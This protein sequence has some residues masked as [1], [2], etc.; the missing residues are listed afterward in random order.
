MAEGEGKRLF[1]VTGR[2]G[3]DTMG[4]VGRVVRREE[5]M[6][7][8]T[9]G[10]GLDASRYEEI[11]AN[12]LPLVIVTDPF[13]SLEE[14]PTSTISYVNSNLLSDL[15]YGADLVREARSGT[16]GDLLH[17]L[18]ADPA[19]VDAYFETLQKDYLVR[20]HEIPFRGANGKHLVVQVSS[21]ILGLV[22]GSYYLQGIFSDVTRRVA[23]EASLR[24]REEVMH[25]DLDLAGWVQRSLIPN[26]LCTREIT[27]EVRYI[28][29]AHVGGDY[30]DFQMVGED[31]VYVSVCDVSGHGVAAAL[32][33][34]RV[35]SEVARWIGEGLPPAEIVTSL[36]WFFRLHFGTRGVFLSIFIGRLDLRMGEFSFAGAGHPPALLVRAGGS[37]IEPLPSRYP[38]VGAVDRLTRVDEPDARRLERGDKIVLYTDGLFE[39]FGPSRVLLGTEG[40]GEILKRH[41][42][43]E[44]MDL[45]SAILEEVEAYRVGPRQDDV[46]VLILQAGA[47]PR[48]GPAAP[49]VSP[50]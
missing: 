36:N 10:P 15:G 17:R 13:P 35:N 31:L 24:K 49:G 48:G 40:L 6:E 11:L 46:S 8:R 19:A 18:A 20:D 28:P 34:N 47:I 29:A 30:V 16:I 5:T 9:T 38:L 44:A 4:P 1:D 41:A 2:T 21:R 3:F 50:A 25:R 42:E 12:A 43:K 37:L 7:N 32:L 22:G 33:A 45:A 14:L 26:S 23:L 39:V 27:L